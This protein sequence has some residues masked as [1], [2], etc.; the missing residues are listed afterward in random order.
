MQHAKL[1]QQNNIFRIVYGQVLLQLTRRAEPQMAFKHF[2]R[3]TRAVIGG[4]HCPLDLIGEDCERN[5]YHDV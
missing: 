2:L 5:S 4:D 1:T 3:R